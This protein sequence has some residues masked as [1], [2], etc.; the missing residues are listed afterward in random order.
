MQVVSYVSYILGF[1]AVASYDFG[2][3][4]YRRTRKKKRFKT[5]AITGL[6]NF[7]FEFTRL[8]KI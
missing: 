8:F 4:S 3:L 7:F 5:S 2:H 6:T 1:L